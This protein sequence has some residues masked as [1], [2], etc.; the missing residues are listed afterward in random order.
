MATLPNLNYDYDALGK[1]ISADIM[2][3]HHSKHHQT[4]VDKLNAAI[5][6]APELQTKTLEE[7]LGSID[8]LPENVRAAVRNHGGGHYNHSLFW[9]WM[10]PDGGG[11][12]TG[13]LAQKIIEKYGT[14]QAFVDE[15]TTKSL[16]VFGSGWCWLQPNLDIITTPNQDTPIMQGLPEPLLGL[17][18]WEHAYYL[19]YKNKRDDYIA[20]WWNVVNW[21]YVKTR[22][23]S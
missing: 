21:D 18:V 13:E 9:Q 16:G 10:S 17:D 12:P 20:A 15:F 14:F 5:E 23:K 4:Y 2:R 11:E 1:Y 19:D 8:S 3:L 6:Q 22:A 7:L